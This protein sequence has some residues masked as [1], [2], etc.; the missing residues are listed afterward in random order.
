MRANARGQTGCTEVIR[1]KIED[2]MPGAGTDGAAIASATECT[3][4]LPALTPDAKGQ[5]ECAAL[6]AV[7]RPKRSGRR[8]YRT[9]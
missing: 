7:H 4:L 5:D 3:G 9:K 6:F 1:V 8:M 2:G